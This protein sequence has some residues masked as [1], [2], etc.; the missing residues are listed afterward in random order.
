MMVFVGT[1]LAVQTMGC[2]KRMNLQLQMVLVPSGAQQSLVPAHKCKH[3]H[4]HWLMRDTLEGGS[5]Q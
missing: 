3:P 4:W 2:F 5:I 1:T